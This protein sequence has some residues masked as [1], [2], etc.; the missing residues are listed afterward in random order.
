M[1]WR[2]TF[3]RY[4]GAGLLGGITA[5]DWVKLLRDNHFAIAPS[6]L[7]RAMAITLQSLQNS[8]FRCYENW[9]Y[10]SKL[11][12]LAVQPPL[13]LLGH[14][15]HGTTHLHNLMTV[16]ERFA[17]ANNYQALFPHSFLSTEGLASRLIAPFL[18]KRRPMDNVE[19][20]MQSPQEDEFALCIAIGKSPCMGWVFPQRQEHYDSYLT[21]RR[22]SEGEAACWQEAFL[23]FL[24]KLT[25]K[26]GRPLVLKS[27]SHTCR[28]RM[29][30]E[31]FP[32]AKFIHIQRNPYA[33]FLSS[34]WTFQVNYELHRLQRTRPDH[35]EEWVLRQYRKMYE[36]YFEE[37]KL[38]PAGNLVEVRFEELEQD[39]LG[40]MRRVYEV[41]R[42]PEFNIV[43]PALRRY[44]DSIV[45]Y[46]KNRFPELSTV[47]RN[48]IAHEWRAS[49]EEWGYPV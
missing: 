45:G 43:E 9:R 22:V 28:I 38:I 29:L 13:F 33:V 18:P 49:F 47:L 17:F 35:L 36:V 40:Q 15:R 42:L 48:R 19:W 1:A 46:Q 24:K 10:G 23:F 44:L 30:L 41:L 26:Y 27:P 20:N 7:P 11:N 8:I 3:L 5:G 21:F 16:D 2:D 4:F 34:V 25:W 39:A 14:W 32:H 12:D 31:T 6:C 37:R